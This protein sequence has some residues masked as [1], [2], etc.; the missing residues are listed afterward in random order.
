M[1][2]HHVIAIYRSRFKLQYKFIKMGFS[3]RN[4]D[5]ETRDVYGVGFAS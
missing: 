4:S 3:H 5:R 1:I 2:Y